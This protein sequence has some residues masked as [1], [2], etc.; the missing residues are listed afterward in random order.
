VAGREWREVHAPTQI[1]PESLAD[2]LGVMTRSVFEPGLNWSV[3]E[4]KWPGI[5]A[6]FADFDP[7][8]VA[9]YTP[10]DVER[11]MADASIIR[12]RKKIEATVYNAGEML[13]V[14]REYDG[15]KCYLGSFASY[16]ATAADLRKRF[17]FLGESGAYHFLY[18]VR[19]PVPD[20]E[21]WMA[22][23]GS[24]AAKV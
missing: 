16:E 18:V 10:A 7:A 6:A 2:Y 14:D 9:G 15:F 24:R 13:N 19:E 4:A 23:H 20:H 11:L 22:T 17:K 5:M 12:N 8:T 1:E 21:V 3:V